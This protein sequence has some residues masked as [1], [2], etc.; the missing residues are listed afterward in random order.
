MHRN[1]SC[2]GNQH[3]QKPWHAKGNYIPDK[4]KQLICILP[5]TLG[6]TEI[7]VS[8]KLKKKDSKDAVQ[9][10]IFNCSS[11]Y[12]PAAPPGQRRRSAPSERQHSRGRTPLEQPLS[13][14]DGICTRDTL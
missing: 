3:I 10:N 1:K 5:P 4:L 13:F 12:C 8:P 6:I 14:Q 2:V 11:R 7:T 9:K